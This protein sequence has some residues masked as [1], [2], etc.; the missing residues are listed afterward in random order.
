MGEE[1]VI[2][3]PRAGCPGLPAGQ[4]AKMYAKADRNKNSDMPVSTCLTLEIYLNKTLS[5]DA[6]MDKALR[7]QLDDLVSGTTYLDGD[8][9]MPGQDHKANYEA[10]RAHVEC[11]INGEGGSLVVTG[12]HHVTRLP[13]SGKP[14]FREVEQVGDGYNPREMWDAAQCSDM[15]KIDFM[16]KT[17]IVTCDE[18]DHSSFNKEGWN[19]HF[20]ELE[21]PNYEGGCCLLM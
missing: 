11:V 4:Q 19:K 18:E 1:L 16:R 5:S 14:I 10:L 13:D 3:M 9:L 8:A 6:E 7:N 20:E 2:A 15:R 17:L 21:N 12:M